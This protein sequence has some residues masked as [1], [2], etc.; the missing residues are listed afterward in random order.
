MATGRHIQKKGSAGGSES[1]SSSYAGSSRSS[2]GGS[3]TAKGVRQ[4]ASVPERTRRA[5]PDDQRYSGQASYDDRTAYVEPAGYDEPARKSGRRRRRRSGGGGLAAAVII[6]ILILGAAGFAVYSVIHVSTLDTIYPN[7]SVNGTDVSGLTQAQA[8]QRLASDGAADPYENASVTVNFPKDQ[9]LV[10]T[11]EELGLTSDAEEAA[12]LAYGYGRSGDQLR[13]AVTYWQTRISPVNLRWSANVTLDEA[14]LT[15]LVSAMAEAVNETGVEA[16]YEVGEDSITV[17]KGSA[18]EAIDVEAVCA[19]VRQAFLTKQFGEIDVVYETADDAA[20]ADEAAVQAEG[21]AF[22]QTMYDE[23]YVEAVAAGTDPD[24]GEEIE[25]VTGVSFDVDAAIR[26]WVETEPGGTFEIPLVFTELEAAAEVPAE[27]YFA[28]LLSEKSTSLSGSTSNRITNIT[29]A[30]EAMDGTVLNPGETFD[31][32][33]CL[34]ERTAA[35]GYKEAGAY[36]GGKHVQELGGGICQG[37]STL[38]YC[39]ICANL[40]ITTRYCHYFTVS[41]LPRGID[42]T[43]SWGG[44]NFRFTNN[45]AYPVRINAWVS[46]GSLTVQIWGT[47]TDGT[48]VE[49]TSETWEDSTYYYAQTYRNVYAADGSLISSAKEAYSSYHKYEAGT[50][51]PSWAFTSAEAN[52]PDSTGSSE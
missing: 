10:I 49:I 14:A 20:A 41:Y 6:L 26:L 46:D 9:T 11:A 18:S 12:A 47:D 16:A 15:G 33:N 51:T 30:A 50:V 45:R 13:D 40:S 37:S 25:A 2:R 39:A 22:V 19:Q 24:T 3:H 17:T 27:G 42:A 1:R 44:P 21:E 32:N 5:E 29:L 43:V 8:A 36:S 28:D 52:K 4:S 34:G 48:H 23:V 38:Y 31:Y 7:V 35:R